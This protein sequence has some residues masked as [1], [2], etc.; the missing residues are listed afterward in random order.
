MLEYIIIGI[1]VCAALG[2]FIYSSV[3]KLKCL[4]APVDKGC[5]GKGTCGHS[6]EDCPFAKQFGPSAEPPKKKKKNGGSCCCG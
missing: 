1:V 6:C 4:L 3:K 5:C 2:Y